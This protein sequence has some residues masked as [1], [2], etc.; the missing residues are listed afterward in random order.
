M[1]IHSASHKGNMLPKLVSIFPFFMSFGALSIWVN[2]H[3]TIA[4]II[5]VLLL[6]LAFYTFFYTR[7]EKYID[8][9]Q[10]KIIRQFHWLWI[11]FHEEES[12]DHFES[13]CI[14]LGDFLPNSNFQSIT[15]SFRY[16]VA[17]IRKYT[18]RTTL[19]GY[20]GFENFPL[21]VAIETTDEAKDYAIKTG[22]LL[23]LKVIVADAVTE[24]LKYD[25]LKFYKEF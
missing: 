12:L 18:S 15:G 22:V 9:E 21:K 7:N 17:L 10:K 25:I 2:S 14:C 1:K 24:H 13:I 6:F 3:S 11:D 16:D 23:N 20:G 4:L 8:V 5:T 19:Q